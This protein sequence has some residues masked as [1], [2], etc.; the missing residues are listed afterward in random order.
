VL[1]KQHLIKKQETPPGWSVEAADFVNKLIMRAPAARLG[2]K[3]GVKEIKAHPWLSGFSWGEL[4]A[5][6]IKSPFR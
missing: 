3:G 5:K 4:E 6:K 1:S 2:A